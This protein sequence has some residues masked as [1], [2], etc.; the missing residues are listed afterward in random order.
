MGDGAAVAYAGTIR[1]EPIQ[2]DTLDD[3]FERLRDFLD[4]G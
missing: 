1:K 2:A 4:G 3:A